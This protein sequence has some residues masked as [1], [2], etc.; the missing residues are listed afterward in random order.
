MYEITDA[1]S[2]AFPGGKKLVRRAECGQS[3]IKKRKQP[4]RFVANV[5]R[6]GYS[7]RIGGTCY[8]RSPLATRDQPRWRLK[9]NCLH[10]PDLVPQQAVRGKSRAAC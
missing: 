6:G 4:S 8:F 5:F 1:P 3:V 9:T 10:V 7:E 2:L